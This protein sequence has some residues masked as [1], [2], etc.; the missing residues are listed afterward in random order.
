MIRNSPGTKNIMKK[1]IEDTMNVGHIFGPSVKRTIQ[2]E[3]RTSDYQEIL[4]RNYAEIRKLEHEKIMQ[5]ERL[6]ALKVEQFRRRQRLRSRLILVPA[7][8]EEVKISKRILKKEPIKGEPSVEQKSK[9][10]ENATEK[11]ENP[12]QDN[13]PLLMQQESAKEPLYVTKSLVERIEHLIRAPSLD[14]NRESINSSQLISYSE[15]QLI[16]VDEKFSINSISPRE[17]FKKINISPSPPKTVIKMQRATA[18]SSSSGNSSPLTP[19][20][21]RQMMQGAR[22]ESILFEEY[23]EIDDETENDVRKLGDLMPNDDKS[24]VK[25]GEHVEETLPIEKYTEVSKEGG[26]NIIEHTYQI[27]GSPLTEDANSSYDHFEREAEDAQT[28]T[29]LT[30]QESELISEHK[31]AHYVLFDDSLI[32]GITQTNKD[33]SGFDYNNVDQFNQESGIHSSSIGPYDTSKEEGH[34]VKNLNNSTEGFIGNVRQDVAADIEKENISVT[35]SENVEPMS[36]IQTTNVE[37]EEPSESTELQ[38]VPSEE[39]HISNPPNFIVNEKQNVSVEQD[40]YAL[41]TQQ[42]ED[43]SDTIQNEQFI[44]PVIEECNLGLQE[45]QKTSVDDSQ[46]GEVLSVDISLKT[47]EENQQSLYQLF[48]ESSSSLEE[49]KHLSSEQVV[50]NISTLGDEGKHFEDI[51]N[52]TSQL[53][54]LTEQLRVGSLGHGIVRDDSMDEKD[55]SILADRFQLSTATDVQLCQTSQPHLTSIVLNTPPVDDL[56]A[57]TYIADI[58]DQQQQPITEYKDT[59][60]DLVDKDQVQLETEP[61][62]MKP[63]LPRSDVIEMN[64]SYND[65]IQEAVVQIQTNDE[66]M[67][68]NS[69]KPKEQSIST[70]TNNSIS[71]RA[72][73]QIEQRSRTISSSSN[74][75]LSDIGIS[76]ITSTRRAD[77][78]N[79]SFIDWNI[80]QKPHGIKALSPLSSLK[81]SKLVSLEIYYLPISR[82]KFE[83]SEYRLYDKRLPPRIPSFDEFL[84]KFGETEDSFTEKV[85][86]PVQVERLPS[87]FTQ[88][89][90]PYHFVSPTSVRIFHFI[91]FIFCR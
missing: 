55:D 3:R 59:N 74:L 75:R 31:Q 70:N 63:E 62:E 28:E 68:S 48:D 78:S 79:S 18:T 65:N 73:S 85:T 60:V 37:S 7:T 84:E 52:I 26:D 4:R 88:I 49:S 22:T 51:A 5:N 72:N 12:L 15:S 54:E 14:L 1:K 23:V 66:L 61:L 64:Q 76:I 2:K 89:Y 38:N 24:E 56:Q 17:E 21:Q 90:Q 19:T 80:P 10:S 43:I 40:H 11:Q 45:R 44:Q 13:S 83:M 58:E 33:E 8:P 47:E 69:E 67:S 16:Q 39:D 81:E 35:K 9:I 30:S 41:N 34:Q 46:T 36:A 71:L 87:T 32:E 91:S 57:L 86:S 42:G 50:G 29:N 6:R 27:E 77:S 82:K 25:I 20:Q 53:R